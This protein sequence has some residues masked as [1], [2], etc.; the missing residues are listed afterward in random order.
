MP[1]LLNAIGV[2]KILKHVPKTFMAEDGT[3]LCGDNAELI[4]KASEGV[5]FE[6]IKGLKS[7]EYNKDKKYYAHKRNIKF[8]KK[9]LKNWNANFAKAKGVSETLQRAEYLGV[10]IP[11]KAREQLNETIAKDAKAK[12]GKNK[13]DKK[14]K[15]A[16]NIISPAQLAS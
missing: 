3:I 11:A 6:Q 8:L 2:R 10:P 14:S 9:Y 16:V 1:S 7:V 5:Y 13:K 4:A 12:K 15:K